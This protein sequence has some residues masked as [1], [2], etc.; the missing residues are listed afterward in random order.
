MSHQEYVQWKTELLQEEPHLSIV[1]PAY[2]EEVRIL[3]TIEEG[4][5]GQFFEPERGERH[6]WN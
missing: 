2:N 3:P 5:A 6:V 4:F 1:I